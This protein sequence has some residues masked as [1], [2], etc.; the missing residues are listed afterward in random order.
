LYAFYHDAFHSL[1][2]LHIVDHTFSSK[3]KSRLKCYVNVVNNG[4]HKTR[5]THFALLAE[6]VRRINNLDIIV[7]G[8]LV[9]SHTWTICGRL[10]VWSRVPVT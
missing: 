8:N 3:L 1:Q 5:V 4:G 10:A 7:S 9:S 6:D 2:S